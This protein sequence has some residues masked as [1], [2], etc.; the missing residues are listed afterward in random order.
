MS[1]DDFVPRVIEM[2][3]GLIENNEKIYKG[4][5]QKL[6]EKGVRLIEVVGAIGAGKTLI[7]ENLVEVLTA[8]LGLR[9][10]V[11]CGDVVTRVDANRIE[12]HGAKVVQINTG[13]ECALNAYHI[14]RVIENMN[15]DEY[16]VV[17]IENVG[18]LICPSDFLLGSEIRIL[19]VSI[20]EG[21]WVIRKHP[22]LVKQSN[23]CLINKM[24]L[25][26]HLNVD[27]ESMVA[28]AKAINGDL[29]VLEFSALKEEDIRQ[30]AEKIG[31][32]LD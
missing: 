22:L 4:Y 25:Q 16:D 7:L 3:E 13:R 26:P 20:T 2:G 14:N 11:I 5:T 31:Y 28:D 24:D 15:L 9:I 1:E 23:F 10:F 8:E 30:L 12:E 19:V 6:Q 18:N 29:D 27:V 21:P 17:F 32:K